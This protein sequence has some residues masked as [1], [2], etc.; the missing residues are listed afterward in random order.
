MKNTVILLAFVLGVTTQLL[1]QHMESEKKAEIQKL[2]NHT[3]AVENIKGVM[4]VL[5][6]QIKEKK[7]NVPQ[8][9]WDEIS[10]SIDYAPYEK[11][12]F[13]AYN[14]TYTLKEIE[15]LNQ[16]HEKGHV[17]LFK[18]KSEKVMPKM[19][20]LGNDLGKEVVLL[21]QEKIVGY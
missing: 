7:P 2:M 21:I 17:E 5:L 16:L 20:E 11:R 12:I 15:E 19:Y 14:D 8:N 18:K 10:T 1:G 3:K 6:K 13:Q 4:N 9:I